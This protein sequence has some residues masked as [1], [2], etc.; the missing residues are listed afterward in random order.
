MDEEEHIGDC[1]AALA[2]QEL[3]DFEV[4]VV[5]AA[6][7]DRTVEI[8]EAMQASFPVPL[9]L[10]AAQRR[11][12]VGEARNRGVELARAPNVAFLSA[13][14]E[15]QAGWVDRAL[16]G[17]EENDIVY[18]RQLHAPP[19]RTLAAAVRGLRYHFPTGSTDRP[20]RYASNANAAMRRSLPLRFPFGSGAQ[21]GAVDDL[22]LT[23][24][25]QDA[26]LEVGYDPEMTVAH[27]DVTT[28]DGELTKNLREAAGWGAHRD[29]LGLHTPML[30]WGGLLALTG[31]VALAA[32][33]LVTLGLLAGAVWLPAL[34]RAV[35]RAGR[36]PIRSLA[37]GA[38]ASPV[39]DL[40]FLGQYLR[41]LT[42]STASRSPSDDPA[43]E[44][45][46]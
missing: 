26:G 27:R 38:A 43:Q 5:D 10:E 13:D 32:P 39:F 12:S 11:L 37:A 35:R 9:R 6:S 23:A 24:R 19:E 1:L 16:A 4:L 8:V 20:E 14:V 18:G 46:T 45:R 25:A 7:T 31:L 15:A 17:L 44:L 34:R 41:Y 28:L 29:E 33:G 42:V 40:A 30:A 3:R 2:D 36:M 22:I 21:A